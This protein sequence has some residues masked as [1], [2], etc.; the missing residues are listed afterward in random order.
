[1]VERQPSKLSGLQI[2]S[3]IRGDSKGSAQHAPST[4]PLRSATACEREQL[5]ALISV[6]TA[7]NPTVRASILGLLQ[8]LLGPF[9]SSVGNHTPKQTKGL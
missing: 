4:A 9:P 1:V 8:S 5:G 7:L 2:R 6:W 3:E